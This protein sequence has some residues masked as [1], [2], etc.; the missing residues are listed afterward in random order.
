[1]IRL[2]LSVGVKGNEIVLRNFAFTSESGFGEGNY[3]VHWYSMV[4]MIT[5]YATICLY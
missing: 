4:W 1:M 3:E 5:E 2:L